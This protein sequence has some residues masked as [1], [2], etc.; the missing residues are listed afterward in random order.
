M[1]GVKPGLG[2]GLGISLL[3]K[4]GNHVNCAVTERYTES[5]ICRRKDDQNNELY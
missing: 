1:L 5:L 2:I 4:C 3:R